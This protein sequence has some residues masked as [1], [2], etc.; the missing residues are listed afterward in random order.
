MIRL[1]VTGTDTGVGKTVIA[2]A[3][4]AL[5][6]HRGLRVA[7]MKPVETGV[8][9]GAPTDA[10]RLRAA[11][12]GEGRPGDVCP[13]T[14]SEPLAPL[15]AGQRAGRP[16]DVAA[17][18]AAFVRLAAERDAIVVE[19]AG[20]LLVPLTD[21][22]SYADVF[23]RWRLGLVIV[24]A[25]RLGAINHVLLTVRAAR[26]AELQIRTVVLNTLSRS[27]D[28][29][30]QT[31]AA[32][33]AQL[34]PEIPVLSWPWQTDLSDGALAAQAERVGLLA[35]EHPNTMERTT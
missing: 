25:N 11:A 23:A 17:L 35:A 7:A 14:Y 8:A 28:A 2:V 3:L 4:V 10:E 6:R 1:G 33:L 21:E 20:G 34:L 27:A 32:A 26:A 16:V 5:L 30:A 29:A 22:A 24:A 18:H 9:P 15:V 12:G 13:V 19:G 31:N